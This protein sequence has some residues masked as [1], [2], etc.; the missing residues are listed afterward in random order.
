ML[1]TTTS[2]YTLLVLLIITFG[3]RSR[4]SLFALADGDNGDRRS[5]SRTET[6]NIVSAL[7][8]DTSLSSIAA[9]FL[10]AESTDRHLNLSDPIDRNLSQILS[11]DGP[12]FRSS[13][14]YLEFNDVT[15]DVAKRA[16][17]LLREHALRA[18][19]DR[20]NLAYPAIY[21]LLTSAQV[22]ERCKV[23]V[24]LTF[25]G[26]KRM[27]SWAVKLFNS[28]G[29]FPSIG[30]FEGTYGEVGS[31]D[32]CVNI[33]A[34]DLIGH[35]HYCAINF[36][37]VMPSRHKYELVVRQEPPD[38]IHLFDNFSREI[39]STP[40]Q[41]STNPP[42][43]I[44]IKDAFQDIIQLAH[45][46]HYLYYKFGSCWPIGCSPFD[47]R[48][49][50][51]LL[52]RMS[53]LSTGPVKCYSRFEDD[54]EEAGSVEIVH[55]TT[56]SMPTKKKLEL[57]IYDVNDGLF[58]VKPHF[59]G[60][61]RAALAVLM[62]IGSLISLICLLDVFL[63]RVPR[64]IKK[65]KFLLSPS[66]DRL[67]HIQFDLLKRADGVD[68][69]KQRRSS[70]EELSSRAPCKF[71]TVA[72]YGNAT[73]LER[74]MASLEASSHEHPQIEGCRKTNTSTITTLIHDCSF[75]TNAVEFFTVSKSRIRNDIL[76]L[77]GIRCITMVWIILAHTMMY[78]DWSGFGRAKEIEKS[79]R[80]PFSQPFFNG[81]YLVDS[82]FLMSGLLSAFT[83]FTQCKGTPSKF[84]PTVY[85]IGRWL[86][87]TPQVFLIS[88]I[89]IVL[90]IA[91]DGPHW[92]L[93]VGE[94]SENC[95]K[96][97]WVNMFHVQAFYRKRRMCNFPTWWI[98]IDSFHHIVALALIWILLLL[99][100]RFGLF[101]T[102]LL[103]FGQVAYQAMRH[104]ELELAP[105]IFSTIPQ[106]GAMWSEMTLD[107]FWTPYAHAV[108]YF[109]GFYIGYLMALKMKLITKF[110]SPRRALLGWLVV[111]VSISVQS[112]STYWW[113]IGEA[114]YSRLASTIFYTVCPFVW[115]GSLGWII[116]ACHSGY[117]GFVNSFLSCKV[118]VILGKASYLI[119]LSH[120]QILFVFFG[121]QYLLL[122]PTVII[123]LYIILGNIVLSTIYGIILCIA[124][125]L[126][127]LK[128]NRRLMKY[129]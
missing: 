12:D 73:T 56:G 87:L 78:N 17:I 7:Q 115:A 55:Q 51:K 58:I 5:V 48:R 110:M 24:N 103:V 113:V 19:N 26:A 97:W 29:N 81:S 123:M 44:Q 27:E 98:S 112:F 76:C 3:P 10:L 22:S 57:S 89:Y 52:G 108:P 105:N 104:Y 128:V 32:T 33:E 15:V 100:H 53:I 28:W 83:S 79:L 95:S 107:F 45:Y 62:L 74:E 69:L 85:I 40:G 129:I 82:F 47:V 21:N 63:L 92:N 84:R 127:W 118:F 4:A 86:R 117:G 50:V 30:L 122:E 88:M 94:Y 111:V 25:E 68:K 11:R 114:S 101:A 49:V 91:G 65:L 38:L 36:R 99:G 116:V 75:I 93:M 77:N 71:P 31:Y 66:S 106:V 70:V 119:Y 121:L 34:N 90:P 6:N 72:D 67:N 16:W 13:R 2:L 42:R 9:G 46:H 41:N 61:H 120:F 124:F 59:R 125:E 54:Y 60:P 109:L 37:P 35:T 39:I 14:E 1:C 64:A 18:I 20:A 126:P 96:N 8:Q 80:S 102:L 43:V 23:S